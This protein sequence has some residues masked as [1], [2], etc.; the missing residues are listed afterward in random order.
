MSTQ[1]QKKLIE[2]IIKYGE[3]HKEL[4]A[5]QPPPKPKKGSSKEDIW[6]MTYENNPNSLIPRG[7]QKSGCIGEFYAKQYLDNKYKGSKI[8]FGGHSQI[9][10]DIQIEKEGF[11]TLRFQVKTITRYSDKY[12]ISPLKQDEKQK[13]H[14]LIVV[15]LDYHFLPIGFYIV[16]PNLD[17]VKS[18][19]ACFPM[20]EMKY[21]NIC[22]CIDFSDIS[23]E[24]DNGEVFGKQL[25]CVNI[26][27]DSKG[28]G[29]SCLR[30]SN[31]LVDDLRA[32]LKLPC[33]ESK[34]ISEEIERIKPKR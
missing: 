32:V 27:E 4:E 15:Y 13:W 5:L 1:T 24:S 20:K 25:S 29:S 34:T 9:G 7:D 33:L 23:K 19:C 8:T 28:Q 14:K 3:A 10:W 18:K 31:N 21:E 2:A 12:T 26:K 22:D 6:K 30:F 17:D 16:S 11:D